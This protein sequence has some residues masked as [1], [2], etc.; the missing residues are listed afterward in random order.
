MVRYELLHDPQEVLKF[1]K[2]L[3]K[4][5]R[6]LD[7]PIYIGY[8]SNTLG[9]VMNMRAFRPFGGVLTKILLSTLFG[10]KDDIK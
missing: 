10:L 7:T 8:I 2:M 5:A 4:L 9:A 6:G 1:C 3:Y